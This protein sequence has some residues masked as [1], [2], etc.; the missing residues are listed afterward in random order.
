MDFTFWKQHYTSYQS[1]VLYH[2]LSPY[3]LNTLISLI[4]QY[5]CQ[6][7]KI[8]SSYKIPWL[9]PNF[10]QNLKFPWLNSKFPDFSPTL[11]FFSFLTDFSLTVGTLE[12][13]PIL[14]GRIQRGGQGVRTPHPLK[15][16]K[17][18]EFL[19]NTGRI[20]WKITN[21]PNRHSMLGHHRPAS[22]TPFY[23]RVAGGPMMAH[24]LWY[25]DPL[26]LRQLKKTLILGPLLTILSGSAHILI[27][28]AN[29][30]VAHYWPISKT[31]FEWRFTGWSIVAQDHML[32][33]Y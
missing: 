20:T 12:F 25:L 24:L 18:I 33:G 21:L 15:I 3:N 14:H 4:G 28:F 10:F 31:P 9:F 19:S 26:S 11:I 27:V 5:N 8:W 2:V 13:Y 23:W 30:Q 32:A 7:A 17:N 6:H 29:K 22:E 1:T 16:H